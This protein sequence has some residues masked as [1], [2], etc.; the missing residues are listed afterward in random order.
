MKPREKGYDDYVIQIHKNV[1]SK[2]NYHHLSMYLEEDNTLSK[3]IKKPS[4]DELKEWE[5]NINIAF[6]AISS[7]IRITLANAIAGELSLDHIQWRCK[8]GA[9]LTSSK[10]ASAEYNEMPDIV[11]AKRQK[12]VL[13]DIRLKSERDWFFN[14][15]PYSTD[16]YQER[17]RQIIYRKENSSHRG[18]GIYTP[19]FHVIRYF[20][21]YVKLKLNITG[22]PEYSD[23]VD[24]D[25]CMWIKHDIL[26]YHQK[27]LPFDI[28]DLKTKKGLFEDNSHLLPK[29]VFVEITN[30][31]G[32]KVWIEKYERDVKRI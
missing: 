30:L 18:W 28:Y 29:K 27:L 12:E 5:K 24:R 17:A 3:N 9:D 4:Y 16:E 31:I 15:M 13:E 20:E 32:N 21:G 22:N 10:R 14:V 26:I 25:G 1:Y 6:Q 7:D 8:M 11:I 19:C 23:I 2:L